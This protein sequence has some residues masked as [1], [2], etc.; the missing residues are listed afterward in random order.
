M[1]TDDGFHGLSKKKCY[2]SQ[3]VIE[4]DIKHLKVDYLY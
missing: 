3:F 1:K 4:Y 2:I